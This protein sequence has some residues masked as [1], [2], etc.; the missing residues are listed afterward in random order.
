M[1]GASNRIW[2]KLDDCMFPQYP[3]GLSKPAQ[4]V[5]DPETVDCRHEHPGGV[6]RGRRHPGELA[7]VLQ[8]A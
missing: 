4:Q 5:L 1:P 6:H 2:H 3:M 7:G 8:D